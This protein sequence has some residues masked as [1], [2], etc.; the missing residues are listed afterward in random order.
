MMPTSEEA[1]ADGPV[2]RLH[3]VGRDVMTLS[4]DSFFALWFTPELRADIKPPSSP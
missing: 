2:C 3:S 4:E 1:T